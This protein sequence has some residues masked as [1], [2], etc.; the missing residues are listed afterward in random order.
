MR[1]RFCQEKVGASGSASELAS[2]NTS[3]NAW[4]DAWH[5]LDSLCVLEGLIFG[6]ALFLASFCEPTMANPQPNVIDLRFLSWGA[7]FYRWIGWFGLGV[8]H[9]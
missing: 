8:P 1:V 5:L 9:L 7:C 2:G 4:D 6:S 3:G